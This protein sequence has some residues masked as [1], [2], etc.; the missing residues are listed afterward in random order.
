MVMRMIDRAFAK[1][2]EETRSRLDIAVEMRARTARQ[3]GLSFAGINSA[4]GASLT[5]QQLCVFVACEGRIW[6]FLL[7][8]DVWPRI[9]IGGYICEHCK[10]EQRT[11]F[12]DMEAL[13][14]DHL[15]E[16]LLEW[17]NGK[18]A[19][20]DAVGLYG[21]PLDGWPHAELVSN[22]DAKGP[23]PDIR[24]PLRVL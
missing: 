19:V 22:D 7:C 15:F 2:L 9:A 3:I 4:I 11:I 5:T 20:A 23:K 24:I 6:D 12:P 17:V 13:W 1:W 8:F 18:L 16:Q 21:S 14:R 10:P